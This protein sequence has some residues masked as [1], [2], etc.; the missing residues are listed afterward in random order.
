MKSYTLVLALALT[1]CS[2]QVSAPSSKN[3]A[4]EE[5]GCSLFAGTDL[6]EVS[7]ENR[8]KLD[9]ASVDYCAVLAGKP[10]VHAKA[11]P[12]FKSTH[13]GSTKRYLGNGYTLMDVRDVKFVAGVPVGVFGPEITFDRQLATEPLEVSQ[14]K[15]VS[16]PAQR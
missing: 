13:N 2:Q 6:T 14:L 10:P 5:N 1:S 11:D 3:P 16:P 12:S 4:S 7:S 8:Q 9:Y 15:L